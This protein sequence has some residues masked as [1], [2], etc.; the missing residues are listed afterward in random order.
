MKETNKESEF[1]QSIVKQ[2]KKAP[3]GEELFLTHLIGY[4]LPLP[5]R[6]FQFDPE[7]RWRSDFAWPDMKI[8]VEIEGGVFIKG[9]HV[10]GL[11]YE[12]NCEKYNRATELG[13]RVYRYS[14]GM[15]K[16]GEAISQIAK[17]LSNHRSTLSN[18]IDIIS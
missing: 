16:R 2:A 8:I 15:V 14:T 5:T 13:Y 11:G 6:Q 18:N 9:G 17:V 1:Y 7:R 10:R 4:G 3:K 12:K